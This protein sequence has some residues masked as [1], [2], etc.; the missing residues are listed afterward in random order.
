MSDLLDKL[1][2][3]DLMLQEALSTLT[4]RANSS[5]DI[6]SLQHVDLI[7]QTHSDLA[8]LLSVLAASLEDGTLDRDALWSSLELHSLK[9]S[10]LNAN[11]PAEDRGPQAGEMHLL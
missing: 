8:K 6:V 3:S 4:I 9:S 5:R 2:A 7:T 10:L 11:D 1:H